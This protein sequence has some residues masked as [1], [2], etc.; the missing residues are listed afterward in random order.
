[1]KRIKWLFSYENPLHGIVVVVCTFLVLMG[2][3]IILAP[4]RTSYPRVNPRDY[5]LELTEDSIIVYDGNRL[6]GRALYDTSKLDST[7]LND[8]K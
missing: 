1:M 5:Q 4:E 8:N 2:A 6:V 7:I 3:F